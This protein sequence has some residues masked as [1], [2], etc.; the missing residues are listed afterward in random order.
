MTF[1]LHLG[2]V[3]CE[4]LKLSEG[5]AAVTVDSTE[6]KRDLMYEPTSISCVSL[7]F[8]AVSCVK[9]E[10]FLSMLQKSSDVSCQDPLA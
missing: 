2:D 9:S 10:F 6:Q 8:R 4:E 1:A 5:P 3:T 7:N